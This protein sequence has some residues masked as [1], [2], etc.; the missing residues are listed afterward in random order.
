MIND[1]SQVKNEN[2]YF[3]DLLF[4]NERAIRA[5]K[6]NHKNRVSLFHYD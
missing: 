5:Y 1:F 6:S 3:N 2:S 4:S